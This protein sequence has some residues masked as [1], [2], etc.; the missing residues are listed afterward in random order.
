MGHWQKES[1]WTEMCRR[2]GCQLILLF[3]C[4]CHCRWSPPGQDQHGPQHQGSP[5]DCSR[6]SANPAVN[7]LQPS[8]ALEWSLE[9]ATRRFTSSRHNTP[10]EQ[11]ACPTQTSAQ[12]TANR[13]INTTTHIDIPEHSRSILAVV[14]GNR[15]HHPELCAR[16]CRHVVKTDFR[17]RSPP[18]QMAAVLVLCDFR[19]EL[20]QPPLL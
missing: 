18:L 12:S 9:T 16:R 7:I 10:H 6:P 20:A 11:T 1:S 14:T 13:Q 2:C 19:L 3:H 17:L 5:A 4:L 8:I 15:G